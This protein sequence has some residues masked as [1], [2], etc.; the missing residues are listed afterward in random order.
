MSPSR[1]NASA[2]LAEPLAD[3]RSAAD[4]FLQ[5][6]RAVPEPAWTR[7]VAPGKWSPAQVAEHVRLSFEVLTRELVEGTG[8]RVVVPPWKGFLLRRVYL[9]RILRTG[10]F[11]RNIRAPREARPVAPPAPQ[12]EALRLVEAAAADFEAACA[13]VADPRSRRLTHPYFGRLPL[14]LACRFLARHTRHHQDQLAPRAPHAAATL[15]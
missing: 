14:P 4:S 5:A 7:P 3:H 12:S 15:R 8:M 9:R 1:R 11:P 6:G 10:R 2:P 13:G